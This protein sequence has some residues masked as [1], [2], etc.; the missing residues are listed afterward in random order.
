MEHGSPMR[1]MG[2]AAPDFAI[3]HAE[4]R[5][6]ESHHPLSKPRPG[7]VSFFSDSAEAERIRSG[8]VAVAGLKVAVDQR[9]GELPLPT[10]EFAPVRLELEVARAMCT[11]HLPFGDEQSNSF[12]RH[13][14]PA[15]LARALGA[16]PFEVSIQLP[17][18]PRAVIYSDSDELARSRARPKE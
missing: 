16:C 5:G 17:R 3:C 6:F 15:V 7:G 1:M 2:H 4:G 14:M 12:W 11:H 10:P 9:L 18:T 8:C 13:S